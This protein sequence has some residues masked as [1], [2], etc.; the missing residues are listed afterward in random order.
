MQHD[1]ND[2]LSAFMAQRKRLM[3]L[4][5]RHVGT[6]T[7]AEDVV[8]DAWLRYSAIETVEDPARLL[9]VIVTRLCLDRLKSAQA[10]RLEYVGEWLPE[11]V[12]DVLDAPDDRAL[13]ISFAVMRTLESLSAA[14]RA[15]FILHDIWDV[16]F[17]EIAST[18]SRSPSACRKLASRARTAL[19]G[20]RKRFAPT[21]HDVERFLDTFRR[22][23]ECG[24][25]ELIRS[26]LADD[27]ELISDGG[28]KAIAARKVVH[29]S[30]AVSRFLFG[31][32]TKYRPSGVVDISA[33]TINDAPGLVMRVDGQVEQVFGF[34]IDASGALCSVYIV[35][36]PDKLRAVQ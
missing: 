16:P 24:D 30:D 31:I 15:A 27:A 26:L 21:P 19:A 35:R 7:E 1:G 5:Y 18:L 32:G 28:G 10:R 25:P 8:Q 9:P 34:D 13:D 22:A 36:N 14:E 11:P 3:R 29:G 17:D 2:R 20:A 4:A 23:M 6:V 33:T 12:G